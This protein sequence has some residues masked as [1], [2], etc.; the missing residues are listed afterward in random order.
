MAKYSTPNGWKQNASSPRLSTLIQK[1]LSQPLPTKAAGAAGFNIAFTKTFNTNAKHS[2]FQSE[3]MRLQH[4][5]RIE[6]LVEFLLAHDA[7][8][9]H[10][11]VD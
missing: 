8:L 11:V 3:L 6:R 10:D 4:L 9:Y 5:V 7:L 1:N 2:L